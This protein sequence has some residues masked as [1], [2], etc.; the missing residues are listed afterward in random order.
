MEAIENVL[1]DAREAEPP[2]RDLDD[3]VLQK[4]LRLVPNMYAFAQAN[5]GA[6]TD[7]PAPEQPLLAK[8][9]ELECAELIERHIDYVK[10]DRSVHLPA[11]FVRHFQRRRDDLPIASAIA[12]LPLVLG[13][14]ALLASIGLDRKTGVIFDIPAAL[15]SVL[16]ERKD[17]VPDAV[18]KAMRLLMDDWLVDV[19]TDVTGKCTL[20]ASALTLIERSLLP[21]RPTFF[22]TAG[23]RVGGK[24]T[25]L[26]MVMLAVTGIRPAAAAWSPNEEE[27]QRRYWAIS[28]RAC[29]MCCGATSRA[30]HPSRV[31]ILKALSWA[32]AARSRSPDDARA[33]SAWRRARVPSCAW[34]SLRTRDSCEQ[35]KRGP[36]RLF[37][38][39]RQARSYRRVD[40]HQA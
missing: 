9:N 31:R 26:T 34:H 10:D 15:R 24:T 21:D 18:A 4:K 22:V 12:T 33:V 39:L 5:E 14:G 28:S 3:D 17:C 20:I 35:T 16:P 7:L 30:V 23:Q 13:D 36:G 1:A 11:P 8:L 29:R 38:R 25:T 32:P 2:M 37:T 6:A 40:R 19:A 27:R